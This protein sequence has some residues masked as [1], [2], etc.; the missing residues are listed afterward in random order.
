MPSVPAS[1]SGI[2]TDAK[3]GTESRTKIETEGSSPGEN[4]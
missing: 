2:L 1:F 3:G 4:E